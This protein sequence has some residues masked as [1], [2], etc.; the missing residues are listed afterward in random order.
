M[1]FMAGLVRRLGFFITASHLALLAL[2]PLTGATGLLVGVLLILGRRLLLSLVLY[3]GIVLLVVAVRALPSPYHEITDLGVAV[4]IG[5]GTLS[6]VYRLSQ[7]NQA[8]WACIL[9]VCIR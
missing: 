5:L 6:L 4:G 8:D 2:V 3:P 1:T 7:W 9:Y